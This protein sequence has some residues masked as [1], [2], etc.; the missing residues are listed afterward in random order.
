M[1]VCSKASSHP[2]TSTFNLIPGAFFYSFVMGRKRSEDASPEMTESLNR[3]QQLLKSRLLSKCVKYNLY[4][5][6]P[7]LTSCLSLS[8]KAFLTDPHIFKN[9]PQFYFTALVLPRTLKGSPT[10]VGRQTE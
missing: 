9:R 7:Q 5:F 6:K 8:A 2:S 3:H 4:V 10:I 1:F